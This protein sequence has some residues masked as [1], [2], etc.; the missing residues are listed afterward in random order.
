MSALCDGAFYDTMI[1]FPPAGKAPHR[2]LKSKRYRPFKDAIGAIDGTHIAAHPPEEKAGHFRNRKGTLSFNVLGVCDFDLNLLYV[3]SGAEGCE[4]DSQ[5][6]SM[7]RE[8][9]NLRI[10]E[11]R[12]LLGD[13]GY[14]LRDQILVPHNTVKYHLPAW[15]RS[16]RDP[17][18][19]KELYNYTH[20]S[21]RMAVERVFG[22]LK[23]RYKVRSVA[24]SRACDMNVWLILALEPT[25]LS[26]RIGVRHFHPGPRHICCL[27]SAQFH[28]QIQ[29]H[30]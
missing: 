1:H 6:Y 15:R 3:L 30:R 27:C 14:A 21:L 16:G 23:A 2:K 9:Y 20:S 26:S 29:G 10:P 4:A 18:S 11:G 7:A 25:V 8:E 13:A 17:A 28:P 24:I 22:V 12:Y 5:V 19:D